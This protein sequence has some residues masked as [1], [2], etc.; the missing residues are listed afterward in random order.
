[1]T[2]NCEQFYILEEEQK[3]NN[4]QVDLMTPKKKDA[5]KFG[6]PFY[7]SVDQYQQDLFK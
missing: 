1:M 3:L 6:F 5:K 7:Q 2:L 4:E